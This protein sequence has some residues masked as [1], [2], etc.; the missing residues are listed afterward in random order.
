[1]NL[2]VD[3]GNTLVKLAVFQ[4]DKLLKKKVSLRPDFLKNLDELLQSFPN[5]DHALVSAVAGGQRVGREGQ[6]ALASLNQA[7]KHSLSWR[8][9]KWRLEAWR[10][11]VPYAQIVLKH[12]LRNALIAPFRVQAI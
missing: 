3:I 9:L 7:L 5:I 11:G 8:G 12:A 6:P 4:E 1:M 2:V 10:T